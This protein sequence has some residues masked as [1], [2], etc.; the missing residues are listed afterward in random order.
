MKI[1]TLNSI[2]FI[3]FSFVIIIP[4]AQAFQLDISKKYGDIFS[5]KILSEDD[6]HNYQQ[7]YLFQEKCKWKSAN[8]HILKISDNILMGHILAQR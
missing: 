8:K 6:V 1:K 4:N 3:I 5:S 2:F 7:A